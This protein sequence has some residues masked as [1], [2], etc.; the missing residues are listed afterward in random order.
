VAALRDGGYVVTWTSGGQDGDDG[1]GVY[2]QRYDA[3]GTKVGG[4][5]Q[6]NTYTTGS[7]HANG[8]TA[9]ADGGYVITWIS[10]GQDG[11]GFGIYSQR[12]DAS[13]QRETFR[14]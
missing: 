4:E 2:A 1:S 8:V 13:G 9:L 14:N 11:S 7:Q 6:V 10:D 12:Y 3:S 5:F